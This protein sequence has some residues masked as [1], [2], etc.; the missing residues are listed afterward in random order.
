MLHIHDLHIILI[1]KLNMLEAQKNEHI[2]P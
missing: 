2:I 1:F